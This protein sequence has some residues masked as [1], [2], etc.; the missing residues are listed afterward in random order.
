AENRGIDRICFTHTRPAAH[1]QGTNA[2]RWD[3]THKLLGSTA[4]VRDCLDLLASDSSIGIVAPAGHL[5][6]PACLP[7]QDPARTREWLRHLGLA[8]TGSRAPFVASAMFWARPEAL[9]ALGR[10]QP[11]GARPLDEGD[12]D[13]INRCLPAVARAG[14]YRLAETPVAEVATKSVLDF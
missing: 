9:A 7:E 5:I 11:L 6:P 4:I 8:S 13:A 2:G 10:S 1:L 3:M 12:E 14:G